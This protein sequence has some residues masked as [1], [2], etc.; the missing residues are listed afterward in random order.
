MPIFNFSFTVDAPLQAVADFHSD[1]SAL[2]KLTP[3]PMIVQIHD[4]E[5]MAEG[6]VSRFTLWAGPLPIRWK[7]VHSNVSINGFTDTQEEGPAKKW[8]HTHTFTQINDSQTQ[9]NEHIDYE[10][11]TGFWGVMTRLLFAK[12]NLQV[13][14][15][16]RKMITRWNLNK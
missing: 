15:T 9:V 6:S 3:P 14:F 5:P 4:I 13:M 8:A 7:A 11:G 16:Y 2:K 12:P 1:T 10:H